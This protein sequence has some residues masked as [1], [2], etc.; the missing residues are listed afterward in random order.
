MDFTLTPK[1][2]DLQARAEKIGRSF[3]DQ[4]REWD[5]SDEAPYR[6]LRTRRRRG[7]FGCRDA[8]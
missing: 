4:A 6:D 2:Q 5:E 7:T 1:Q 8:H 3:A